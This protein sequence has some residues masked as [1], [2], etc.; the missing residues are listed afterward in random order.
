MRPLVPV[1]ISFISG[2][3]VSESLCWSYGLVLSAIFFSVIILAASYQSGLRFSRLAA[4][5]AFFFTGALFIIPYSRPDIDPEHILSRVQRESLFTEKAG[6]VLEG[7]V[8]QV[9]PSGKRTRFYLEVERYRAP[10][11]WEASSGKALLSVNGRAGIMPGERIRT[12]AILDEPWNLGNPGEFDYRKFLERKGVFVTGYIKSERLIETVSLKRPGL[13]PIDEMRSRI[14]RFIDSSGL[15]NGEPLKA[16]IISGQ[17]GIDKK[18]KDAFAATGTAHILSI[19]GLHVGMVAAFSYGLILFLMKRSERLLLAVNVRKAALAISAAPVFFY[20]M[21]AGFPSPTQRAVIMVLAF[22]ASFVIGRGKDYLNTLA[23]A[24]IIILAIAPYSVWDVSFQL[25]FAAVASIIVL[26]PWMEGL[27]NKIGAGK[28]TLGQANRGERAML[29]LKRKLLP[30]ALMTVAAGIGTSAVLAYHFHRVSMVGLA[31]NLAVVPLSG[32]VVPLLFMSAVILPVSSTIALIPLHIADFTFNIIAIVVEFFSF[33]PFASA[34]VSPP[35]LHEIAFFYAFALSIASMGRWTAMRYAALAAAFLLV[36]SYAARGY[37]TED[38]PAGLRVTFLSVGQGDSSFI[39]F[40]D[41]Q[42]M[43]IDGGGSNNPDYDTGERVVAPFLR[44]KS[45]KRIDYMVLTHAQ[46]DHMGGLKFIVDNFHVGEFWWNGDGDI[47]ELGAALGRT[48]VPVR[49]VK[50]L[51][52]RKEIGGASIDIL[53]PA[54]G[55]ALD[56]NDKSVVMRVSYGWKSFL[57]TGDIGE[58]A[59][60]LLLN[61]PVAATV[62]KAPHHGSKYSSS[63]GFLSMVSPRFVV[64]SAGRR[65]AFGQPHQEALD[66]YSA[67][68]A[69]IIRTDASGAVFFETDG[70]RLDA[71]AYLTEGEL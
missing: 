68:G 57:F 40:A 15:S 29:F 71:R 32:I 17:G 70:R 31:A 39:E 19:S 49:N 8:L 61:K 24:A 5:P 6:H 30:I 22:T 63:P 48:G 21:L 42:T 41:G 46:Q 51:P 37:L 36:A 50:D 59:E 26:V 34:W 35:A 12:M 64:V 33:F 13:I 69:R 25:T 47:G 65:N 45:I 27:L 38:P 62:L 44:I 52:G 1:A 28:D 58:K 23:M 4:V 66:R 18:L 14:G 55:V 11:G 2:I 60:E 10:G 54:E 16:L 53:P 67:A 20:G 7:R 56:M 43:L 9:E 3:I